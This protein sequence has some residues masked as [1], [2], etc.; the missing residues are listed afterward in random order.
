MGSI[1]FSVSANGIGHLDRKEVGMIGE[2]CTVYSLP[3]GKPAGLENGC[4][5]LKTICANKELLPQS[6]F[7]NKE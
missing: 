4:K 7:I 6:S 2:D 3:D 1:L 5:H